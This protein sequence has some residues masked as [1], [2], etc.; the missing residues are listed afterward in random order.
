MSA[1]TLRYRLVILFCGILV[2]VVL[3][4]GCEGQTH[5]F[6]LQLSSGK[7]IRVLQISTVHFSADT[8]AWTIR[9]ETAMSLD[10]RKLRDEAQEVW[11][12]YRDDVERAGLQTA[13]IIATE[14]A[15]KTLLTKVKQK[16]FVM[17]RQPDENWRMLD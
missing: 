10:D 5:G 3:F 1:I 11:D 4:D 8:P 6:L 17:R 2:L 16:N 15:A 12:R 9:Y 13:I 14:P 7:E